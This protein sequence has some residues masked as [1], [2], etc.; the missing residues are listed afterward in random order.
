MTRLLSTAFV[1]LA[2]LLTLPLAFGQTDCPGSKDYPGITRM[3]GYYISSYQETEFDSLPFQIMVNGKEKEEAVEGHRYDLLYELKDNATVPSQLQVVRNYQNAARAVGG[4]VLFETSDHD[5]TTLR[6]NKEG[7]EVWF[8]IQVANQP[9][10]TKITMRVIE[11]KAMHQD[12]TLDAKAMADGLGE[13]GR[14]AVY[15]IF[16]DTGKSELKAESA[17]ALIEIAKLLQENPTLK[18]YVVGH[19]DMVGDLAANVKLSQGRAQAVVNGLVAQHGIA[20]ARLIAFGAGPYAPVAS[21]KSEEGRA[22]N[23][24]VELVEI[25]TK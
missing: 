23:R 18:L 25:A 19:T 20:G 16:F 7:K 11:K 2:A 15:G 8:A 21:N 9:S 3:P 6:V 5:G 17:P 12:V 10:G 4:Q 24:R 1:G 13:A 14:V 22:K